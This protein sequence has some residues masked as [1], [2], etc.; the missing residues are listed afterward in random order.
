MFSLFYNLFVLP[1]IISLSI[2]LS[3][4]N[5]KIRKGFLGRFQS[6]SSLK[7]FNSEKFSNIYWFHSSSYGEYDK[8]LILEPGQIYYGGLG[9][10]EGDVFI[11]CKGSI[12]DLQN[13]NGI[14][15]YADEDYSASLDIQYCNVINGAYYGIS[16]SGLSTGSVI[17]CN[18]FNNEIGIK[19][20][21]YSEVHIE[22]CNFI[23]NLRICNCDCELFQFLG[24]W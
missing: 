2:I 4:F 6:I 15:I 13:Q 9:I 17:N 8:Y 14:W 3:L 19:P 24:L 23:D 11:D 18:F 21:D 16:Y 7:S 12:I 10:Y 1:I 5:K 20:F 22:N